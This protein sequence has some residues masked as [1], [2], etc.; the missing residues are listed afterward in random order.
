MTDWP[1]SV[2]ILPKVVADMHHNPK[3]TNKI[4]SL[5]ILVGLGILVMFVILILINNK[6]FVDKTHYRTIVA[7]AKGL[8]G[9]PAVFFKGLEIGRVSSFRLNPI[10]NDI[11]VDFFVFDQFKSKVVKYAVLGGHRNTMLGDVSPFDLILPDIT[12]IQNFEVLS[13]GEMVPHI[14]SDLAQAYIRNGLIAVQGDSID[15]IIASVNTL[16]LNFQKENNPD[17]G[18]I[19]RILDRVAKMTDHL[20]TVSE[21]LR[22]SNILA[23]AENA[24]SQSKGYLSEFP[25][26]VT[27]V[28]EV[29]D[30]ANGVVKQASKMV[31]KYSQPELIVGGI[32]DGKI[33]PMLDNVNASLTVLQTM[34]N[35]V[36]AEREQLVITVHAVQEVLNKL[37]KTLQGLNNNPLLKDGIEEN[38]K[39]KGI[40]MND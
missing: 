27:R 30:G 17:A 15:S 22:K 21:T 14:D 23:E 18:S 1:I 2:W 3:N 25:A 24:M 36:H 10:N 39:N 19:F 4:V 40:E 38:T 29:I 32:T 37:D 5:F 28:N 13:A 20:L 26:I 7:N 16:L 11:E 35:D 6:T 12:K 9:K 33:P 31:E 8:A 34:L